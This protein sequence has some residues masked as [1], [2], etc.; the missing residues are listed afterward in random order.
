MAAVVVEASFSRIDGN[1]NVRGDKERIADCLLV[2][3]VR[4]KTQFYQSGSKAKMTFI[5]L[6]CSASTVTLA[7]VSSLS[8]RAKNVQQATAIIR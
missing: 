8:H 1:N 4:P 2:Q 7:L 3:Y 5:N 6:L